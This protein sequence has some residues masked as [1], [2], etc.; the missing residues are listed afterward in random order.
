MIVETTGSLPD[1]IQA[2]IDE[3]RQ[4][5][6]GFLS[7][8][9]DEWQSNANR[10]ARSGEALLA[11]Y[12]QGKLA[13]VCG[14]N[15]DPFAGN[16]QIGRIRHLYVVRRLRRLGIGAALVQ[17]AVDRAVR[18][19]YTEV[20]LRTDTPAAADFYVRRGFVPCTEPSCTHVLHLAPPERGREG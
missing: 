17:A 1:E 5:G 8:L 15:L 16:P 20:R 18:G 14:L 3:S 10:F 19:G 2:L 12:H 11:A 6:F 13:G 7:R 9:W 4:E